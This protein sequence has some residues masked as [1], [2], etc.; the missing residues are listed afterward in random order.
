MSDTLVQEIPYQEGDSLVLVST[1]NDT[2]VLVATG[3]KK[4]RVDLSSGQHDD[5]DKPIVHDMEVYYSD[6]IPSKQSFQDFA[7]EI[8]Y[9]PEEFESVPFLIISTFSGVLTVDKLLTSEIPPESQYKDSVNVQGKFV[10]GYFLK[11]GA[12]FYNRS[13]GI[14]QMNYQGKIWTRIN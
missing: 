13:L 2:V 1:L 5:C 4:Y 9:F 8:K 11:K 3:L 6:F 7:V 10:K 12:A 14:V